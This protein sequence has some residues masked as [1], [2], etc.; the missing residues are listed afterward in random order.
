MTHQLLARTALSFLCAA[1][2]IGTIAVDFNRTHAT[3]PLWPLHARFHVVW[4]IATA[5]L[6]AAL[7]LVL[8][9][10]GWLPWDSG[11]Y[12]ASAL[13]S[14][15]PLGF[16]TAA[17]T[18]AAYKG[19]FSDPNGIPPLRISFQGREREFD[20]NLFVVLALLL[21]LFSIVAWYAV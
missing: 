11:F 2:G 1:Q 13:A 21:F 19:A 8:I 3:N 18:R 9:W 17:V 7:E 16:L 12:L 20:L 5:V 6:M 10:S 4:Q 15:S 14:F